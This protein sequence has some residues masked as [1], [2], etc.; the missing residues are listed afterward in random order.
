MAFA[1]KNAA[2]A[3]DVSTGGKREQVFTDLV[4]RSSIPEPAR[5]VKSGPGPGGLGYA[6]A[7]RLAAMLTERQRRD[8]VRLALV[9]AEAGGM[10]P[11][12]THAE[13]RPLWTA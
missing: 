3:V 8:I 4:S 5:P 12:W 1:Y 9:I 2:H 6:Q 7:R 10:C 13:R 11:T